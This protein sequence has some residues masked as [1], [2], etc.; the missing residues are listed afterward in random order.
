MLM[1]Q[2]ISIHTECDWMA[3]HSGGTLH[4][5]LVSQHQGS[6]H[7]NAE[8]PEVAYERIVIATRWGMRSDLLAG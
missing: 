1:A 7:D 6:Q 3:S 2:T 8:I 5:Q 4:W